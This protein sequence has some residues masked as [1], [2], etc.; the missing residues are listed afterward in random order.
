MGH[1][2]PSLIFCIFIWIFHVVDDMN[3]LIFSWK[4]FLLKINCWIQVLDFIFKNTENQ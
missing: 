2:F 4:F 1:N 3:K